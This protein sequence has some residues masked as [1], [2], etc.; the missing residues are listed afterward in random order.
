MASSGARQLRYDLTYAF[1]FMSSTG[2]GST[3]SHEFRDWP[4]KINV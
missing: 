3:A 1:G 4:I 2:A